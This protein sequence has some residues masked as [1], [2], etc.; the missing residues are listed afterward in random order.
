MRKVSRKPLFDVQSTED[1]E[2]KKRQRKKTEGSGERRSRRKK[3]ETINT[4]RTSDEWRDYNTNKP[5]VG[6]PV[7][8]KVITDKGKDLIF[9]GFRKAAFETYI[10]E[11]YYFAVL[12]KKFDNLWYRL[13]NGCHDAWNC[14]DHFPSCDRC[15]KHK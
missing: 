1:K 10:D 3:V 7:E 4:P 2:P 5:E 13:I 8:F 12:S 14:P 6:V 15:P 9:H 11:P